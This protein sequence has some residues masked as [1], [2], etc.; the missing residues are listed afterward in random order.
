MLWPVPDKYSF[1][2]SEYKKKAGVFHKKADTSALQEKKGETSPLLAAVAEARWVRMLATR[3][4][5][6]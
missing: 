5:S 1:M 4:D 2:S 6:R 3:R